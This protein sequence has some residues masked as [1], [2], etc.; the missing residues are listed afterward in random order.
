MKKENTVQLIWFIVLALVAL[1]LRFYLAP[2]SGSEYDLGAFS[3]WAATGGH[4]NFFRF[5]FIPSWPRHAFPNLA[6]YFPIL[7]LL[8]PASVA[9]TEVG[10]VLLKTP[11]ILGDIFLSTVV[12]FS[13]KPR[14]RLAAASFVLFNPAVWFDSAVF[15]QIDSLYAV[16][17]LLAVVSAADRKY[18]LAWAWI[19]IAVFF[20]IQALAVLPIIAAVHFKGSGF[21]KMIIEMIPAAALAALIALPYVLASSFSAIWRSLSGSIGMYPSVSI[22]A[23]NPWFLL[24]MFSRRWVIDTE[25]VLA[26]SYRNIGLVA[27]AL[28]AAAIIYVLPRR[29]GRAVVLAAASIMVFSFFMLTTEMHE[30]YLYLFL[31]IA[32][33]VADESWGVALIV[34]AVSVIVFLDMNF[35]QIWS[36]IIDRFV[37]NTNYWVAWSLLLTGLYIEFFVWYIG[38]A[39]AERRGEIEVMAK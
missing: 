11:A 6:L 1:V 5:Y 34:A 30:R 28:A 25:T 7:A 3:Y 18:R 35:V 24:H 10:R 15:G 16:F 13:A 33:L 37:R 8:G 39:R 14:W 22:N 36:P 29:P 4:F 19:V 26:V 20:K 9:T 12:Y 2:T 32:I 21:K 38:R 31:P 23:W 27:F 17:A